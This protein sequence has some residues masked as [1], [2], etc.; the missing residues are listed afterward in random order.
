MCPLGGR[1]AEAANYHT[2]SRN[3][4]LPSQY[5]PASS[6]GTEGNRPGCRLFEAPQAR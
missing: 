2:F 6:R 5:H 3:Y 4:R 1:Y